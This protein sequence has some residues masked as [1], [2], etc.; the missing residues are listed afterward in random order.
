MESSAVE[1]AME[2]ERNTRERGEDSDGER[3]MDTSAVETAVETAMESDRWRLRR[4][5]RRW[6]AIDGD[7]GGGD[8]DG[9]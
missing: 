6:R 9:G 5:R 2:S 1:T 7:F 3:S 4:W 8:G